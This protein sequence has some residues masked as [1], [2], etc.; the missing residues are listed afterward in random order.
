MAF[1]VRKVFGT[2]KKRAPGLFH[3]HYIRISEQ[4]I[5]V[6]YYEVC[7][8]RHPNLFLAKEICSLD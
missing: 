7:S 3:K 4:G 2:F 1:R 5:N 6:L 8:S